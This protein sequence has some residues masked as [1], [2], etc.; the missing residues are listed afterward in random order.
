MDRLSLLNRER[1]GKGREGIRQEGVGAV[2]TGNADAQELVTGASGRGLL[3]GVPE[4]VLGF[5]GS[6]EGES[7]LVCLA[8]IVE[9]GRGIVVGVEIAEEEDD[10]PEHPED[11]VQASQ[12]HCCCCCCCW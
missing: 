2:G 9:D 1:V 7:R 6:K 8:G 10:E 4:V 12:I 3:R 11:G 5:G